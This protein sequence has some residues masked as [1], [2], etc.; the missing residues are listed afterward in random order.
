MQNRNIDPRYVQGMVGQLYRALLFIVS[1]SLLLVFGILLYRFQGDTIAG[2]FAPS[3]PV[4]EVAVAP[5]P[6]ATPAETDIVD[7]I[8]VPTGLVVADGFEEVRATCT[9]CHSAKLVTQNRATREGWEELIRW[10]QRTQGLWDLGA[11]EAPILDY[12]AAYYAPEE[13]GRRANLDLDAVEWYILDG[14]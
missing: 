10:M 13:V 12:L 2:W 8:H 9:A 4:E 7:G 3:P 1:M 6:V 11:Q 5:A 14:E